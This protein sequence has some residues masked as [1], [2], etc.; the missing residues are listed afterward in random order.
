MVV[1]ADNTRWINS[2]GDWCQEK[3][4][5]L[6]WESCMCSSNSLP[7]LERC[8]TNVLT[9][10]CGAISSCWLSSVIAG[11]SASPQ[12]S[13]Y[14]LTEEQ[15]EHG[16]THTYIQKWGGSRQAREESHPTG[17]AGLTVWD[18]GNL[19]LNLTSLL[20]YLVPCVL[21]QN[22]WLDFI[23]IALSLGILSVQ[24]R[25]TASG[26]WTHWSRGP[27]QCLWFRELYFGQFYFLIF[28]AFTQ[29]LC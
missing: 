12:A 10:Q 15:D 16:H 13:Q 26:G 14:I 18:R 22:G 6:W 28:P 21:L 5:Y 1:F 11:L 24:F 2:V 27:F 23:C 3:T 29:A 19:A 25:M 7:S 9:G 17:C 8:W 20:S 4:C